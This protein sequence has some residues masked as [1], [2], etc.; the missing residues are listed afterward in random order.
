MEKQTKLIDDDEAGCGASPAF[1]ALTALQVY[2]SD[3]DEDDSDDYV[4][5]NKLL[6]DIQ[7]EKEVIETNLYIYNL[8]DGDGFNKDFLLNDNYLVYIGVSMDDKYM[9]K[10]KTIEEYLNKIKNATHIIGYKPKSRYGNLGGVYKNIYKLSGP[11]LIKNKDEYVKSNI[12]SKSKLDKSFVHFI[13]GKYK[14]IDSPHNYCIYWETTLIKE[15][16]LPRENSGLSFRTRFGF[17]N[18]H[19]DL[20]TQF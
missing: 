11:T 4:T 5:H 16:E 13:D 18:H 7:A 3:S 19:H 8:S 15:I 10:Y 2:E 9:K 17:V 1:D 14:W 6:K 12:I 20:Y